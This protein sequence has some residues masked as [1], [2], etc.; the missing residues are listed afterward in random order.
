MP[1]FMDFHPEMP[2]MPPKVVEG[3]K[4]MLLAGE[5]NQ[6]GA[7]GINVFFGTGGEAFCLSEAPDAEAV[8][9]SHEA[10]GIP[11]DAKHVVEVTPLV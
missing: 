10:L 5:A 4:A 1:K 2:E 6:F 8:L 7:T 11:L 9:K 3:A